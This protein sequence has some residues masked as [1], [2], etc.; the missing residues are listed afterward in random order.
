M[1]LVAVLSMISTVLVG[2]RA[3]R[4][5]AGLGRDVRRSLF[6][7][8]V[9]FSRTEFDQFSTASLITRT[10]NDVQQIQMVMVMLFRMVFYA[11]ILGIGGVIRVLSTNTNM[12]WIIAVARHLNPGSGTVLCCGTQIQ[13]H[14]EACGQAQSGNP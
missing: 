14:S 12:G 8:V 3:A 9:E 5:S 2:L 4:M 7:K 6:S 11:P 10:T 13:N 1:L